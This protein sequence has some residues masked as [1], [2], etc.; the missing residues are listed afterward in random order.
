VLISDAG[1]KSVPGTHSYVSEGQLVDREVFAARNA[2]LARAGA[3]P[4]QGE[5]SNPIYLQPP[6]AVGRALYT[7]FTTAPEGLGDVW[8][9]ESLWQS[10]QVI[11][12][13]LLVALFGLPIGI[14]C[15]TFFLFSRLFRPFVTSCATCRPG[16]PA[17]AVT[18]LSLADE[19]KIVIFIGTFSRWCSW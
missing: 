11:F 7:A 5:R 15:G 1:D 4:A 19:P 17:L 6:H 13:G 8:L 10:C 14:L 2:E 16:V 9:H 3:R 12:W 18:V